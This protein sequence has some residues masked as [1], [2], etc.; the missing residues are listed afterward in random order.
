MALTG[1]GPNKLWG[2]WTMYTDHI[3]IRGTKREGRKRDIP[4]VCPIA[5]PERKYRA[6]LV[7]LNE[8]SGG[9]VQPYD[10]R[11]TFAH[12]MEMAGISRVRRKIYLGHRVGDVTALSERHELERL[13]LED[14][15]R[16]RAYLAQAGVKVPLH[17]HLIK[18]KR[19]LSA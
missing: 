16:L 8:A 14:G 19:D 6:F 15:E 10:L 9:K 2:N 18:P 1:M 4:R 13:W 7:A 17:I 11:R 5:D 12:W 3:H